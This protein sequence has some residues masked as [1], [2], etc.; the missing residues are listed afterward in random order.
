MRR[1][2][3][4]QT[5]S[6]PPAKNPPGNCIGCGGAR[7][8]ARPDCPAYE[9]TCSHC[10]IRGHFARVCKKKATSGGI[11]HRV[12]QMEDSEVRTVNAKSSILATVDLSA[13]KGFKP[14]SFEADTGAAPTIL[15]L[16]T[17]NANFS[18]VSLKQM[19][20]NLRN[21]DGSPIDGACGWFTGR[22]VF[23]SRAHQDK[24]VVV[25]DPAHPI[26]WKNFLKPLH[27]VIDCAEETVRT[28]NVTPESYLKDF[29]SLISPNL[30]TFPKYEHHMLC[31]AEI[32]NA[33]N[34]QYECPAVSLPFPSF[35]VSVLFQ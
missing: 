13:G 29:P 28:V 8:H 9:K 25:R 14:I 22:I 16:S 26:L 17:F 7:D 32:P 6:R 10:Q 18:G 2:Q 20:F 24:V 4:Q 5:Q 34:S 35:C 23:G 3:P 19:G 15:P 21:Y 31:T 1:Q 33:G 12:E 27:M 11:S 30:G